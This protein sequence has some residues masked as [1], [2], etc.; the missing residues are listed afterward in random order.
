[1]SEITQPRFVGITAQAASGSTQE[2]SG[3]SRN[4]PLL[5]PEGMIGSFSRNFKKSAKDWNK[6]QGPTTLGPRRIC[7]AAQILR[8]ASMMYATAISST[9]SNNRLSAIMMI[10]G[11][12]VL[13][14]NSAIS[15]LRCRQ[16]LAGGQA[17]AFRH[18]RGRPCHRVGQVEIVNR[19]LER[20]LLDIAT[21]AAERLDV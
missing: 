18:D 17:G 2:T 3:A 6:P 19:S 16:H 7:T 14:Q 12:N 4:T 13:V 15:S 20:R 10:S 11:H 1:M 8:S 21:V 9:T 5:A